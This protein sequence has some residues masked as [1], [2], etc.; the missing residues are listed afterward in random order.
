M[1]AINKNYNKLCILQTILKDIDSCNIKTFNSK[2]VELQQLEIANY[3]HRKFPNDTRSTKDIIN[4]IKE[5]L[6]NGKK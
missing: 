1:K 3:I 6:Y 4:I 2:L 5:E